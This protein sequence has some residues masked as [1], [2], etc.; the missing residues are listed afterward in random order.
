MEQ[1]ILSTGISMSP[2]VPVFM[3]I[4]P[5]FISTWKARFKLAPK[6][7]HYVVNELKPGSLVSTEMTASSNSENTY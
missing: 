3:K 5:A 4:T 1:K 7:K 2:D 6:Q